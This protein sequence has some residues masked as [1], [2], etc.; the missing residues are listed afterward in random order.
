MSDLSA[1]TAE[2]GDE[3]A[4]F[5]KGNKR[6]VIRGNKNSVNIDVEKAVELANAGYK[7][8]GHTHP[9]TEIFCLQPSDGDYGI[10]SQFKQDISVIY[11]SKGS[12]RVFGK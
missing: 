5:T 9:G 6:L 8:S 12:F 2:T 4:L 3:F 11:N 10:L 7:W 1:L